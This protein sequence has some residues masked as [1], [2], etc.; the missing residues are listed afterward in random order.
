MPKAKVTGANPTHSI[1]LSDGN[2]KFG[3]LLTNGPRSI[4][5]S[6]IIPSTILKNDQGKKYGDFDP[7]MAHLEQRTWNGGRGNADFVDDST[8]YYTGLNVTTKIENRLFPSMQWKLSTGYRSADQSLPG[9]MAWFAV[10]GTQLYFGG[11]FTASA[12][13]NADKLYLWIRR[14]GAPGTLNVELWSDNA[15]TPNAM[16]K[17]STVSTTTI[18]DTISVFHE[19]DWTGTQALTSGTAY[20]VIAYGSGADNA[21]SHWEIGMDVAGSGKYSANGSSWSASAGKPYYR[22]V[23][24]DTDRYWKFFR[25]RGSQFAVSINADASASKL[26]KVSAAAWTEIGTTGLG[27]VTDVCVCNDIVYFAQGESVNIRRM[28]WDGASTYTWADDGTNKASYMRVNY[29][30]GSSTTST[31]VWKAN[32]PTGFAAPTI[33]AAPAQMWGT[34]LTFATAIAIGEGTFPITGL[35]SYLDYL[36]VFTQGGPWYVVAGKPAYIN[37]GQENYPSSRNGMASC[38]HG[39]FVFYSFAESFEQLYQTTITDV[40][41][42]RGTGLPE[43][44]KG[45]VSCFQSVYPFL[46]YAVDGGASRYSSIMVWDGAG[47]H[48]EFVGYKTGK[49]IRGMGWMPSTSGKPRLW[50]DLGGDIAY[51]DF[52]Q[53][54]FHPLRDSTVEYQHESVIE[55]STWDMGYS[56]LPKYFKEFT[57]IA[58]NLGKGN[59]IYVGLDTQ[60]DDDIGTTNWRQAG[61]FVTSPAQTLPVEMGDV[62]GMRGRLRLVTDDATMPPVI[63]SCVMEGVARTPVKY[64]WTFRAKVMT[65]QS[66]RA[67]LP[68]FDPDELLSWLKEMAG[69]PRKIIMR[70]TLKALDNKTVMIEPPTTWRDLENNLLKLWG[71]QIVVTVR[72]T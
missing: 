23:D 18:T 69:K 16:L 27:A 5:E 48:D 54:T 34:S 67:G 72:E 13:Y 9:D 56:R 4:T 30:S 21:A 29:V 41:P 44:R 3:F 32:N 35:N 45:N 52:A 19:F 17:A 39:Q 64:Q 66:N 2:R 1:T 8:R 55:L 51:M 42:W 60:T 14:V 25:F 43:N 40:G 15:G 63:R 70:S 65:D 33:A 36:Y 71:G 61:T 20:W 59:N 46:Y 37:S 6:P 50:F 58:D 68:D 24:A 22:V 26:Y 12:S 11:S 57:L 7:T 28:T 62:Y 47:H 53:D 49:R 38:T 31:Y 10:F